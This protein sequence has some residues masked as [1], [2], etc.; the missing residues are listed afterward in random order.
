[1]TIISISAFWLTTLPPLLNAQTCPRYISYL[2]FVL[3]PNRAAFWI[4]WFDQR[5]LHHQNKTL[6][7]WYILLVWDIQLCYRIY[8]PQHLS[9]LYCDNISEAQHQLFSNT[10]NISNF[11]WFFSLRSTLKYLT[12]FCL[13]V[14][15]F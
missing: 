4:E 12:W 1:M 9:N 7:V 15:G 2:N 3:V 14:A 8:Y 11:I 10:G 13:V 5:I 6:F